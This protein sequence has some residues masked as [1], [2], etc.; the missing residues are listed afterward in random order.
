MKTVVA[1]QAISR[2]YDVLKSVGWPA[3]SPMDAINS[4]N[5]PNGD[6]Q[7]EL[8]WDILTREAVRRR[9]TYTRVHPV[10][11]IHIRQ[12]QTWA[13]IQEFML[14]CV[15]IA[16]NHPLNAISRGAA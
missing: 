11:E 8:M 5:M 4:T 13:G 1:S 14:D 10:I 12:S 16:E 2:A 15:D 3:C 6:R 7:T 9:T